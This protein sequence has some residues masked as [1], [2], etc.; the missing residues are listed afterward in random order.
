MCELT[1]REVLH[2]VTAGVAAAVATGV[3]TVAAQAAPPLCLG[4]GACTKCNCRGFQPKG[5]VGS[6]MCYCKHS[7]DAHRRIHPP[8]R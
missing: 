8:P 5:A 1:R 2:K 3:A 4:N 6:Q 7:Y